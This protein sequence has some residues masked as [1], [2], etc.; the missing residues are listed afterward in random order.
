M[1]RARF[2]RCGLCIPCLIGER[3]CGAGDGN[4]CEARTGMG[5]MVT[6]TQC[7][8]R[9]IGRLG[10]AR[11]R[12]AAR[13]GGLADLRYSNCCVSLQSSAAY[14]GRTS[15]LSFSPLSSTKL[16]R[17]MAGNAEKVESEASRTQRYEKI[18]TLTRLWFADRYCGGTGHHVPVAALGYDLGKIAR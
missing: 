3:P 13:G 2:I 10:E 15:H 11:P 1:K 7:A 5:C 6:S 16:T 17:N 12:Q 14:G 4:S 8:R 9:K 18:A